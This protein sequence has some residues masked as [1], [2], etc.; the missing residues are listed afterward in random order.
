MNVT[1]TKKAIEIMQAFVDGKEIQSKN[2]GTNDSTWTESS[3]PT[4]RFDLY[5]YRIKPQPSKLPYTKEEFL[6]K[7]MNAGG[8]F[9]RHS[10]SNELFALDRLSEDWIHIHGFKPL[11]VNDPSFWDNFS[12][13]DG[14][15]TFKVIDNQ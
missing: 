13:L 5:F 14:S 11:L 10:N 4:W 7:A 15:P 9:L 8:P 12:F 6:K 1:E 2:A 3:S